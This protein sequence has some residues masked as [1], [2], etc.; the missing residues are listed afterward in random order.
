MTNVINFVTWKYR[1]Q[2]DFE[3]TSMKITQE[4]E[5]WEIWKTH[6]HLLTK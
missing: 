1:L 5:M 4:F 2:H 3:T 6:K